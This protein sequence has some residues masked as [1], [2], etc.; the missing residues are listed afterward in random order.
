MLSNKIW[1]FSPKSFSYWIEIP[2]MNSFRLMLRIQK[3]HLFS[4]I[5]INW[6]V[7]CEWIIRDKLCSFFVKNKMSWV[8]LFFRFLLKFRRVHLN[9]WNVFKSIILLMVSISNLYT[10]LF[11]FT[12]NPFTLLMLLILWRRNV[13][14]MYFNVHR[15]YCV[16][17]FHQEF[18][19]DTN[20]YSYQLV[21]FEFVPTLNLMWTIHWNTS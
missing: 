13:S 18:N 4:V 3:N 19:E 15:S 7:Y 8:F 16:L 12:C 5:T 11:I 21:L 1:L 14:E 6:H 17:K 10:F 2:S 20:Q 9:I